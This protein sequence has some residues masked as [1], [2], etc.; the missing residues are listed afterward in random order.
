MSRWTNSKD[1][2]LRTDLRVT[3]RLDVEELAKI[4]AYATWGDDV[5]DM[6]AAKIREAIANRL[7]DNGTVNVVDDEDLM[8]DA[9]VAAVRRAYGVP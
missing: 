3:F 4:L 1:G 5:T 2:V 8:T 7:Y 6:P 9:H